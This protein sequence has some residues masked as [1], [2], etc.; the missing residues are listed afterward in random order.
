MTEQ[1]TSKETEPRHRSD[2]AAMMAKA[3]TMNVTA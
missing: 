2:I 3:S 1:E